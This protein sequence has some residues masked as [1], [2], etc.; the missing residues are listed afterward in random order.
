MKALAGPELALLAN[1]SG[2]V[3]A[4]PSSLEYVTSRHGLTTH[5]ALTVVGGMGCYLLPSPALRLVGVSIGTWTGWLALFGNWAR[6]KG[7]REML[8]EGRSE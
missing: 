3:L 1:F 5:R 7:S 4:R 6:M 8:A 2:Y